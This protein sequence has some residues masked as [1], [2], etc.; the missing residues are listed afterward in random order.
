M[1][2]KRTA[3]FRS[4]KSMFEEGFNPFKDMTIEELESFTPECEEDIQMLREAWDS[5]K[6]SLPTKYLIRETECWNG[7][8]CEIWKGEYTYPEWKTA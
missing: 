3:D 4:C 8:I 6:F 2:I 1:K 7:L 5:H